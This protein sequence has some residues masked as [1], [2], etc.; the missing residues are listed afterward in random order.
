[1]DDLDLRLLDGF[2]RDLPLE[3]RPFAAIAN[4]LNTSEAEVIARLARLRDEG[5]IARIGATC[6][7]N[8]AGA[9]TLAA[10]RVPVRRIDKVAALV[11]AEPGVN[12]SYLREGSDWNLWFVATAPDAEA[13]EESLVRIETATGLVPLS[14]PL[15]RAFNIDLG[16]PLIGPRRAM[17]LDRPADLDVLRP[18]DKALMQAL[19]T[20]LALVPRPFVALGQALG[21]SEA[22]VISRIRALA[23][24][25]ILTRV[26][27]IVRHRALGWCENAMVV[28]R[29]PEPA[30]EAAGTALAAV[31]GVTLCYQRRTVP[32][33][34]NWPLFCM[35]HAR[36]RAE[37]ME[38]L[39]QARAL[40]EL[41]GV[42]HRILFST[43]CFRQRGAVIAE[44]A[45]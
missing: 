6:R 13:L 8:T 7:P 20:G 1:M 4:R 28:W 18:R 23:A 3:T 43:R 33:L 16:F 11:G 25:R 41:Q 24:A 15:V 5:L 29:L 39:V 42:P 19:T 22:E 38:V 32:G 2:Q 35:I 45:A 30:V 12:H 27:V 26:G 40:P 17:A 21:R 10:L 9:S 14:L 44:V 34:W 37:A 31:P 36:S